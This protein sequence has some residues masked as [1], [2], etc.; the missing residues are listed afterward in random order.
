MICYL[1]T[2]NGSGKQYVGISK[3]ELSIRKSEHESHA[4]SGKGSSKNGKFHSAIREFGKEEFTWKVVAEGDEEVIK[5]LERVL[6]NKWSTL[7]PRGFNS[8]N[9]AYDFECPSPD[10]LGFFEEMDTFLEDVD[11][12]NDLV[13]YLEK[14]K[15]SRVFDLETTELISSLISKLRQGR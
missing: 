5:A 14:A 10:D 7:S 12:A 13:G 3:R 2:H 8:T 9:E 4:K 11:K 6:I 15:N 1:V